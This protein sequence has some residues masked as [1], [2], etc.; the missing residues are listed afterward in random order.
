MGPLFAQKVTNACFC[1]AAWR[2]WSMATA[3]CLKFHSSCRWSWSGWTWP[4]YQVHNCNK[5]ST[6][7]ACPTPPESTVHL[8]PDS[9]SP[10]Y[11]IISVYVPTY[12]ENTDPHIYRHFSVFRYRFRY[13]F[14]YKMS[15]WIQCSRY[16]P[17]LSVYI[18]SVR[19]FLFCE[20]KSHAMHAHSIWHF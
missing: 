12:N 7:A 6:N 19:V 15:V 5:V 16:L 2:P 3:Q 17:Y 1:T 8:S 18:T 10:P 9:D 4:V 20:R 13:C 14:V 11:K